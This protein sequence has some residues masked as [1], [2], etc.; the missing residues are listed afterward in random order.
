MRFW[1]AFL[2]SKFKFSRNEAPSRFREG[3]KIWSLRAMCEVFDVM[4]IIELQVS[5]ILDGEI[6]KFWDMSEVSNLMSII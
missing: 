6:G 2:E 5:N 4:S 3:A 1:I